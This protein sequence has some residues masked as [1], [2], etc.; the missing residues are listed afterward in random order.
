[1]S[2]VQL[3][4]DS[5]A[6]RRNDCV[7]EHQPAHS[8]ASPTQALL[9]CSTYTLSF[10][11]ILLSLLPIPRHITDQPKSPTRLCIKVSPPSR[12][13]PNIKIATQVK[14]SRTPTLLLQTPTPQML[15]LLPLR[16][17]F[18]GSNP[19]FLICEP[20]GR[21]RVVGVAGV[22]LEEMVEHYQEHGEG[23]EEDGEGVEC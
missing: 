19:D 16:C 2:T 10:L 22:D 11:S 17:G 4:R 15:L 20:G 21:G 18:H 7:Q 14:G 9:G 1:V 6:K 23:T 3:G 12:S 5:R 13:F 8:V